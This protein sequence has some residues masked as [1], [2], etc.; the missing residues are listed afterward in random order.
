MKYT[1]FFALLGLLLLGSC[2]N[3]PKN[4]P[5]TVNPFSIKLP[6]GTVEA[7]SDKRLTEEVVLQ[8]VTV[9]Y[10]PDE[11]AVCLEFKINFVT[12]YQYWSR[13]GREVFIAA[14]DRYKVD[15]DQRILKV[16]SGRKERLLYGTVPGYLAW[17]T[18]SLLTATAQ[19]TN[20]LNLGY[21]F[22]GPLKNKSPYFA[23][24]QNET[25]ANNVKLDG[26]PVKS[27]RIMLYFT[28]SQADALA[29][30]FDQEYLWGLASDRDSSGTG[31][32]EVENY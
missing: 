7:Q 26:K 12:Y 10:L 21:Y 16:K 6:A 24:S 4:P 23:I 28:R 9:S 27:T 31:E 25:E 11:D 18:F 5:F 3:T 32:V 14:L 2:A 19:G 29:A 1:A 20:E 13:L 8:V 30:L 15:Y 17:R 22:K